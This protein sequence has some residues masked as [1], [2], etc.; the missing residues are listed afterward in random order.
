M[1][2]VPLYRDKNDPVSL[3]DKASSQGIVIA[4]V[5]HVATLDIG[6][7][8]HWQGFENASIFM[9]RGNNCVATLCMS[10][11]KLLMSTPQQVKHIWSASHF[12]AKTVTFLVTEIIT[13][14]QRSED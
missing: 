8:R 7:I 4:N 6:L 11:N 1:K 9:M 12:T 13:D 5:R 3:Y 10:G 2:H 14:S